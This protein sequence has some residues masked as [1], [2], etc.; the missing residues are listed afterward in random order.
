MYNYKAQNLTHQEHSAA[1]SRAGISNI[2]PTELLCLAH[3]TVGRLQEARGFSKGEGH[4]AKP[5][6]SVDMAVASRS[7][8]EG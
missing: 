5:G 2:W 6:A 7:A 1:Y 4:A 3:Q 8:S